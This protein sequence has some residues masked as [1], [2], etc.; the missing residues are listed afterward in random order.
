MATQGCER[1]AESSIDT[2]A[3]GLACFCEPAY[4]L[5]ITEQVGVGEEWAAFGG[6]WRPTNR[7]NPVFR[8]FWERIGWEN[9][10]RV[11]PEARPNANRGEKIILSAI[12]LIVTARKVDTRRRIRWKEAGTGEGCQRH[13]LRRR[14]EKSIAMSNLGCPL[15]A[16]VAS[17]SWR[18]LA[19]RFRRSRSRLVSLSAA[20]LFVLFS[21]P[22]TLAAPASNPGTAKERSARVAVSNPRAKLLVGKGFVVGSVLGIA[23]QIG[24]AI[25]LA[26]GSAGSPTKSPR[27]ADSSPRT[28]PSQGTTPPF[29]SLEAAASADSAPAGARSAL[30]PAGHAEPS[31]VRR[32]E[33]RQRAR[34]VIVP[35]SGTPINISIHTYPHYPLAGSHLIG[36]HLA[37]PHL[38]GSSTAE[39]AQPS[40]RFD[41]AGCTVQSA[42]PM[43][44]SFGPAGPTP[45]AESSRPSSDRPS[46]WVRSERSP[47]ASG[48]AVDEGFERVRRSQSAPKSPEQAPTQGSSLEGM[49]R[50]I[51]AENLALRG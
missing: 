35:K 20:L 39:T 24:L 25:G 29:G 13:P 36:P 4:S 8:S 45:A 6:V 32:K 43:R 50:S 37:G 28:A 26:P 18:P 47:F 42:E 27:R 5:Q 3:E 51:I 15:P 48:A 16:E 14:T 2:P 44:H 17:C 31:R 23:V 12:R 41:P 40:I 1:T 7:N 19:N 38:V 30:G 22:I 34:T 10:L 11:R 46:P 49:M 9:R 33:R 21:G